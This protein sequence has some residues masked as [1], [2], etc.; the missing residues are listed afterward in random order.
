MS[1]FRDVAEVLISSYS[2]Y[3]WFW[4]YCC[5]KMTDRIVR[6]DGLTV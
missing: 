4:E 5:M 3:F 2:A 1:F 6:G